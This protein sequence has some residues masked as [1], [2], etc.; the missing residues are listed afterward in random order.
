MKDLD[1]DCIDWIEMSREARRVLEKKQ[2]EL[3]NQAKYI[4]DFMQLIDS[5]EDILN[6]NKKLR[7]ENEFLQQQ[8]A[9]EKRQKSDMETKMNEMSKLSTGMAK[10]AAQDD[11]NKALR[12]YLNISKR[13][14]IGKREAAKSVITELMTSAKLELPD[15]IMELLDHLDDEQEETKNIT[16]NGNYNDIHDNGTV[17][18]K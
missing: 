8:L 10:K 7:D 15:D 4:S 12:I 17:N 6:E 18:Q 16:V 2:E 1:F 9:D 13:K 11:F 14:T 5:T 3:T